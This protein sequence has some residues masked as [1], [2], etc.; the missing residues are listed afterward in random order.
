MR[1]GNMQQT[2]FRVQRNT[3]LLDWIQQETK[4]SG[5]EFIISYVRSILNN[6]S[7]IKT[8]EYFDHVRRA[9]R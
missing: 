4:V 5:E 7:V 9:K 2:A 3:N 6:L 1:I 8:W